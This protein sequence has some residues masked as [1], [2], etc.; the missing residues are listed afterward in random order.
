MQRGLEWHCRAIE[1]LRADE[2][3]PETPLIHF[4]FAHAD[5]RHT[6]LYLKDESRLPSGSSKHR[7]LR[8][9][10]PIVETGPVS[11]LV[12]IAYFARLIGVPM[13]AVVAAHTSR[14]VRARI[15]ELGAH[16]HEACDGADLVSEAQGLAES[17][18][19]VFLNQFE[20]AHIAADWRGNHV[21]AETLFLQFETSG[22]GFPAWIVAG[23]STGATV[24]SIGRYIRSHAEI[25]ER[26]QLCVVD[27]V[28]SAYLPAFRH[29]DRNERGAASPVIDDIGAASVGPGFAPHVIDRMIAA[30][31]PASIAACLWFERASGQRVSPSTGANLVGALALMTE[32]R[33]EG[34]TGVVATFITGDGRPYAETVF[35]PAWREAYKL[36]DAWWRSIF[37]RFERDGEFLCALDAADQALRHPTIRT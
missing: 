4:A 17:L 9:G 1:S 35:N 25:A 23:A 31:D 3:R 34:K 16:V 14:N 6:T 32:M 12:A 15:E 10:M 11:T 36:E 27:P 22:S 37:E 26:T 2:R 18:G 20:T 24:A 33:R 5:A 13:A 28:G 7:L 30:P 8:E 21:L 29:E 19:G